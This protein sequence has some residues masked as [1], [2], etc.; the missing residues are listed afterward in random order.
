D[1]FRLA[2]RNPAQ[3]CYEHALL[4]AVAG[5]EQRSQEACKEFVRQYGDT[6]NSENLTSLVQACTLVS[7]RVVDQADLLRWAEGLAFSPGGALL[8]GGRPRRLSGAR[9]PPGGQTK[10]ARKYSPPGKRGGVAPLAWSM[11]PRQPP[12][13]P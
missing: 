1:S 9:G 6:T 10:C 13:T 4:Q 11:P 12:G 7:K 5:N 3:I 2:P 8:P